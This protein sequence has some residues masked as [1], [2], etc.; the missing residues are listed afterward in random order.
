M[1]LF[2]IQNLHLISKKSVKIGKKRRNVRKR[3]AIF[4]K[5]KEGMRRVLEDSCV[6][7]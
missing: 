5:E 3:N 1:L 4:K 7:S 2:F 6:S